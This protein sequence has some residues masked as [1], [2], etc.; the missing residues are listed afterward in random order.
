MSDLLNCIDLTII[1]MEIIGPGFKDLESYGFQLFYGFKNENCSDQRP[2]ADE[3]LEKVI[4]KTIQQAGMN[5]GNVGI[6]TF[7]AGLQARINKSGIRLISKDISDKSA[8]IKSAWNAASDWLESEAVDAV[9][10]VEENRDE[11]IFSAVLV[12]TSKYSS[13]NQKQI[14]AVLSGFAEDAENSNKTLE[15]LIES[16]LKS[17][18]LSPDKIGLILTSAALETAPEMNSPKSLTAAFPFKI[19]PSCALTGGSSGLIS[20]I[21]AVWC[22]YQRIIPGTREWI[23]PTN[24]QSWMNTAFYVPTESQTWFPSANQPTRLALAINASEKGLASALIFREG[25][26]KAEIENAAMQLE[27]FFLLPVSAESL[28]SL[29][30]NLENLQK[31]LASLPDLRQF[32]NKI[33]RLWQSGTLSDDFVAC[34]LG[35]TW[36]ELN[37]EIEFAIKGIPAAVETGTEW[38]TPIGSFFTPTPLGKNGSVTF[39]YPGAFNSY[40]G[41]GRDLFYLF[42]SLYDRLE[43]FST[44]L[45]GLLN[46]KMLYPRS[47]SAMSLTDQEKAEKNLAADPLAMLISGTSLAALFTFLLRETFDIHPASA[48]GYSLGE[49]SMMFA[50]GVWTQADEISAA[51]H[52]SP[53]F[54]TRLAGPQN[55]VRESWQLPVKNQTDS[56]EIIWSS[57]VLMAP[58]EAVNLVLKD[59][60]KVFMTHINTPR[61]VVIAGDPA[62]CRG[63]IKTLK[64]ISLQATYDY[65]LH[66]EAMQSEFNDLQTLLSWPVSNQPNMTLYSAATYQAFPIEQN[67]I[68]R[69][70]AYGLCHQLDFSRLVHQAYAD[71]T[72]IFIELGAGS[73]C[74]HWVDE[75]LKD[76]VH[77]AFSINRKGLDDHTAVLQLLAKL[78]GHRVALNLSVVHS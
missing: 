63:V 49:I 57:F 78:I 10:L 11:N 29:L 18:K 48:I 17:G 31:E 56:Y 61:Q 44:N 60:S 37:R 7:Q 42:P 13:D 41:I 66:C 43:C 55:A 25:Q 20:V 62:A 28:D 8:D 33:L 2:I 72:R 40:P 23:A 36:D 73:N 70:I 21:K 5:I 30:Q 6:V 50:S 1:G 65:A 58:P 19:D 76:K 74:T 34:I 47:I 39:V 14:L 75:S 27:S 52:T 24:P 77:A 22:I 69:Q 71:G 64:C 9:L 35:H 46:E 16:A 12:S 32:S 45:S 38:R 59:E 26:S 4:T 54:H 51:L 67:A 3:N 15:E 68:A 53:L